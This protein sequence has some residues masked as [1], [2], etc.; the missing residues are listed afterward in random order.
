MD[1]V[2]AAVQPEHRH[3][4]QGEVLPAIWYP[5][6]PYL[7]LLAAA[8]RVGPADADRMFEEI[9]H[10]SITDTMRGMYKVFNRP[11]ATEWL[12]RH[13]PILWNLFF[14][15]ISL[16]IIESSPGRGVA[17]TVG[18]VVVTPEFCATV[19]GGMDAALS[20]SG[21]SGVKTLHRSCRGE[22]GAECVFEST[23]RI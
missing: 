5:L 22:G 6:E 13:A 8:R 18:Q 16:E 4:F 20:A 15:G 23:W 3:V 21:A 14:T 10:R 19:C 17:R 12:I 11:G 7:S 1:A 2:V 9:G